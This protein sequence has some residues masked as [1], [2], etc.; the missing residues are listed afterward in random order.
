MGHWR[1][2]ANHRR[3]VASSRQ[4]WAASA[5]PSA[6]RFQHTLQRLQMLW[7]LSLSVG[8]VFYSISNL[9]CRDG[10]VFVA[11]VSWWEGS[12]DGFTHFQLG[13]VGLW[14]L[15][16]GFLYLLFVGD[17]VCI[18]LIDGGCRIKCLFFYTEFFLGYTV[19]IW[20]RLS[21]CHHL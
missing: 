1:L 18:L 15:P 11:C 5:H 19:R 7:H 4:E 3:P 20:A 9:I 10:R 16:R 2:S 12:C 6:S 14:S 17:E 21:L 8:D 13:E